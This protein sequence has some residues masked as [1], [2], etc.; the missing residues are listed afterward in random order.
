MTDVRI[1]AV[2]GAGDMGHGIAELAA[3]R[4]FEVRL[5]DVSPE[6]LERARGAIRTSLEKLVAKNRLTREAAEAALARIRMTTD[7]VEAVGVA[8]LVI[9]AVPERLDLKQRV[10][11]EVENAASPRAVLATNTSA[12]RIREI[13]AN[14]RDPSRLVGMHFFNPVLLM[15]L[16]EIIPGPATSPEAVEAAQRVAE[17]LGKTAVTLQKDTPGFV[18][19]RLVCAWIGAA[20]M[21][22][23]ARLADRAAI[24]AAMRFRAGFPMGPFELADYTGLDVGV[25]A[26]DYLA[27]RLG[28]GYRP[29]ASMRALVERGALGKKT[30]QG[31]YAWKDGRADVH[32]GADAAKGFDPALVLGLVVNEAAKLLEQGVA[33]AADIDLACRR[34][35]AFP[36]GPFEWADEVGVDTVVKALYTLQE[37]TGHP[38]A[39]PYELLL[40]MVEEG[41]TGKAAGRGFHDYAPRAAA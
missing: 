35:L 25:H 5:R 39:E 16:V 2:L 4:G 14:L 21:A 40:E 15:D 9:E 22:E 12:M 41:R 8:D 30:G 32:L 27:N 20:A 28:E 37:R 23:E 31:F 3:M 29:A 24:D 17:R 38:L 34:G 7:L 19:S 11:A 36:K 26:S 10:F 13:G 6:I 18:T 1:I 33:T